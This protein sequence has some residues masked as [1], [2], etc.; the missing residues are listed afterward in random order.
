[1]ISHRM[2]LGCG[3]VRIACEWTCGKTTIYINAAVVDFKV[4][5]V[6]VAWDIIYRWSYKDLE[7]YKGENEL[8]RIS[9]L[10]TKRISMAS[11]PNSFF[12]GCRV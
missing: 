6:R 3:G 4:D 12:I 1:L 9:I 5:G 8:D 2:L 10:V 7:I 11:G